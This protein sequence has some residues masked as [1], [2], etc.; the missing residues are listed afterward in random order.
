[1]LTKENLWN[2]LKREASLERPTEVFG[3]LEMLQ[4]AG[5]IL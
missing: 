1:M 5:S 2:Y 3:E 4:L